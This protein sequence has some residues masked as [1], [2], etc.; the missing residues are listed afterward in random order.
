[1]KV[2][3]SGVD[4]VHFMLKNIGPNTIKQVD[5]AEGVF[6]GFVQKSAKLRAPKFTGA[7]AESIRK[8]HESSGKWALYVESP[9]GWFQETG[10]TPRGLSFFTPT[11]AG[12]IVGEWMLA[13]GFNGTGITPYG[14]AQPFITPAFESGKEHLPQIM[15]TALYK[16]AKESAK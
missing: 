12:L 9:Y 11:R 5:G 6:M 16:A 3:M 7:L 8:Y 4:E 2:T 15:Q 13:H 1:M 14:Q 10:W